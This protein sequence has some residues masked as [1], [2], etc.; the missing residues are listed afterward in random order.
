MIG[1]LATVIQNECQGLPARNLEF[2]PSSAGCKRYSPPAL[3]LPHEPVIDDCYMPELPLSNPRKRQRTEPCALQLNGTSQP[4][5]KRQKL[6]HPTTGSQPPSAFWDNL[7][8]TWLTRGALREL[9]RRNNQPAS[10]QPR[11]QHRR[12]RRPVTRNFLAELKKDRRV[13]QSASEFL[14]HCESETLKD[15]KRFAR[16]GGPDLSDLKGVSIMR[17]LPT[18]I[19]T[20]ALQLPAPV[21]PLNHIMSSSQSNSRSRKRSLASTLITGSTTSPTNTKTTESSG[22]YSRNFQQKL[23]DNG[24][25][26]ERYKYPDGR[27]LPK[28]DNLKEINEILLQPRPSLSPSRFSNE[29]FEEF[30]EADAHISKENKATKTVIPAI[31]GKITDNKCVEGDVLFT[32]LT[33]PTNDMLTAA[34]PDLYYGARPEQLDRRVR[35]DLSGYI[36]PSTQDD[37]PIAPN[38]FLA[39]KGPNGTDAVARRQACYDGAL[40]ARGMHSLQL[41]GENEPVYDN[42]AYTITSIYSAGQLKLYTSHPTQPTNPEDRSEYCMTQLKGY[43]MTSDPETFRQGATAYRNARDWAEDQRDEAITR[44]NKRANDSEGRPEYC[45]NQLRSFAMTDTVDTFRQGATA[46]R[47]ARDWAKDQRDEAITRANKRANDS[48]VGRL[49]VDESFGRVSNFTEASLDEAYTIETLSQESLTSLNKGSNAT[50]DLPESET[51]MDEL[52]LNYKHPTKR[53]RK[54]SK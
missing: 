28:P 14:G 46:Y 7:S 12:A 10:N 40:G 3:N 1:F 44:A 53:L 32:N 37:L 31:E 19:E 30:Q 21:D 41:Y 5:L 22:P 25:Y 24:I 49:A 52:A 18:S 47:N 50:A 45:M 13:T 36:I 33:P 51:S 8:K 54:D 29:N 27:V 43:S 39:A 17:Y 38:F 16:N 48:Q 20:D 23:I 42:N 26:P 34:K 35:D 9:N 15:I 6:N 4:Q 11:S 2:Q